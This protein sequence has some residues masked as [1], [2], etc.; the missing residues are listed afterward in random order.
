MSPRRIVFSS[1]LAGAVALAA[2]AQQPQPAVSAPDSHFAREAAVGGMA[3]V[4]LGRLAA[5]KATN[6]RVKEFG[7]RMVNDHS[8][9]NDE[10][11]QAASQQGID[12]PAEVDVKNRATREK[13]SKLSGAAFDRAY[14]DDM[15]QDHVK[16]VAA[17]E[18]EARRPGADS[19]VKAFAVKTLPTLREH[20]QMAR[21]IQREV[22]SGKSASAET[23]GT[24]TAPATGSTGENRMPASATR[25][26]LAAA[27]GLVLLASAAILARRR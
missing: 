5:D 7:Q 8:K 1:L 13:L 22:A 11:K 10:L 20:L 25:Y 2:A 27:A 26:P 19:A 21:D 3:E 4:E 23:P 17:F 9:A 18:T 24:T 14:M 6:P 12:L 15:V 16:D